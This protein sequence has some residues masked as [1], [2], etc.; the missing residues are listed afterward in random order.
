MTRPLGS[1]SFGLGQGRAPA[2][3]FHCAA[4]AFCQKSYPISV[5]VPPDTLISTQNGESAAMP[6]PNKSPEALRRIQKPRYS[7]S[8][9]GA[10]IFTVR[11]TVCPGGTA[12][13]KLTEVGAPI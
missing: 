3:L 9:I 6:M 2:P 11:S 12:Y 4:Q 7:P 8:A 5:G 10:T 13:G 1:P